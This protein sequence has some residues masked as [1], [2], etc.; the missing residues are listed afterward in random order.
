MHGKQH[1][2][3]TKAKMCANNAM[4]K[5]EHRAKISEA[6][7]GKVGLW[8]NSEKK[9]AKPGTELYETLI[10]LGYKPKKELV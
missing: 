10:A 3:L 8:I 7:K 5:P 9:M 6:N 4:S 1:S 2:E